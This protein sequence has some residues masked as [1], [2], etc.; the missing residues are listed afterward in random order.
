MGGFGSAII[1]FMADNN[2][3][4]EVIRLGIPDKYINH[5]TQKELWNECNFDAQSIADQIKKSLSIK[6]SSKKLDQKIG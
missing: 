4:A 5:G 3:Q 6:T 2:Y 1:E